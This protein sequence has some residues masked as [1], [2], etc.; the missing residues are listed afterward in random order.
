MAACKNQ[1]I[2]KYY[3][4]FLVSNIC[5]VDFIMYINKFTTVNI[6]G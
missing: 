2:I 1:L 4:K 5:H 3:S 6:L